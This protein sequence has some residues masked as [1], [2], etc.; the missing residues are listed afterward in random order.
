MGLPVNCQSALRAYLE[1]FFPGSLWQVAGCWAEWARY[2]SMVP[3]IIR[4]FS[5]WLRFGL[6]VKSRCLFRL[7]LS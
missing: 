4:H 3:G 2:L 7:I 1:F 6:S 5:L